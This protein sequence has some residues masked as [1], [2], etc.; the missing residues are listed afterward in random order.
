MNEEKRNKLVESFSDFASD[1]KDFIIKDSGSISEKTDIYPNY[2]HTKI[3]FS[4][5]FIK[6]IKEGYVT[7]NKEASEFAKVFS[8]MYN[9]F[10]KVVL[11]NK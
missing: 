3:T 6:T 1:Y 5:E 4:L 10:R 8:D 2:L 9:E 7:Y 11:N